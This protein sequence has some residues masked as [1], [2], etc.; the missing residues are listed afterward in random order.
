[1]TFNFDKPIYRQMIDRME[2]QIL[3]DGWQEGE[4]I[5]AVRELA[6]QVQVNPNTVMRAYERLQK[7]GII[8]SRRGVGYFVA[9]GAYGKVLETRRSI[10]LNAELPKIFERMNLLG[11]PIEEV[12]K[13]YKLLNV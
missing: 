1:M 13:R 12:N 4:R 6:V 2:E 11:I 10:F 5:P 3:M 7:S 8:E 9:A